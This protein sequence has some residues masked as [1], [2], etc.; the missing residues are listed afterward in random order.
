MNNND[1]L[2]SSILTLA[3]M[4]RQLVNVNKGFTA[5]ADDPEKYVESKYFSILSRISDQAF[6]PSSD[7]A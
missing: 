4:V 3:C 5:D 1:E 6:F 7:G 2:V